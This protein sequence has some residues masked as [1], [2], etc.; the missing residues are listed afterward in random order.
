MYKIKLH[1]KSPCLLGYNAIQICLLGLFVIVSALQSVSSQGVIILEQQT[2]PTQ[3]VVVATEQVILKPGFHAVGTAG[4]FSA[5]I[6]SANSMSPIIPM[7]A[8]S[9]AVIPIAPLTPPTPSSDQNYIVTTVP[10]QAVS[11]PSTL[12]NANSNYSI[13]YFD[14]LGRLSQTVQ[15]AIT[16]TGA[17][18]VSGI[19]YDSFGR[20]HIHWLPGAVS[21]N[22][23]AY[24]SNFGSSSVTTNKDNYPYA[25]TEYDNSPLNRITGQYG[26]GAAWYN[27]VK[28]NSIQYKTNSTNDVICFTVNS[29]GLLVRNG[30]YD[31]N[32]LYVTLTTDEDAKLAAEYKDKLGRVVLKR[33]EEG[34]HVDTY[35]VFNDLGQ[36]SFVLPP[37]AVDGLRSISNAI[38]ATNDNDLGKL[39]YAYKYDTRGN[40]IYKKL[41]GCDPVYMVYDKAN[42][43][44]LSQDGNQRVNSNWTQLYYDVFGKTLY[45][46]EV[47]INVGPE[48]LVLA[49][50]NRLNVDSFNSASA[51]MLNTGYSLFADMSFLYRKPSVPG[52]PTYGATFIGIT[53]VRPLFVNYYDNYDFINLLTAD[54]DKSTLPFIA[55][56]G[57]D[58]HSN[59]A[60]GLL[61]GTR[62][63]HLED[64]TKFEVTANYYD[65]YGRM[66]QTRSSNHLGGYDITYNKLDFRGKVLKVRKEHNIS[67][68]AVA[69]EVYRYAYDK[70]ERLTMTRYK[71]GANDTI[72]LASNAYDDLGRI[73]TTLRHNNTDNC[74]YTY[75]IRNWKTKITSG[76]FEENLY[77]NSN[78]LP[79]GTSPCYNGNIAYST[80]TYNG[81]N[82]GYAYTYDGLNRLTDAAFKQGTSPQPDGYFDENFSYDSQGN[83]TTLKRKKDNVLIDD[84]AMNLQG[85]YIGNQL[86]FV[87]DNGISQHLYD[88]KE[89]NNNSS[90]SSNEFNYDYNGN[91]I[92]DSDRNIVAIR[93]N[94]LNL[95]D[96]IQF[97]N[98][99]QILNSYTADGRKIGTEYFTNVSGVNMPV[100]GQVIKAFPANC[101]SQKGTAY[102]DNK[103]YNTLNGNS[104]LT[105]LQRIYN[106]EGYTEN[107]TSSPNY[108]YYRRD[109]LGDNREVWLANTGSTVQR[110]Q[111][112][113]SGLPWASN[114]GDNPSQQQRKYNGKEFVEM[115]GYDT[116]DYGARGMYPAIGRFMCV[117]PH[118]E[119]Y[120]STSPYSYCGANPIKFV[121]SDGK[122]RIL[123]VDKK[124]EANAPIV[125]AANNYNDEERVVNIWAHGDQEG[126][127]V[128]YNNDGKKQDI[129][130][131]KDFEKFLSINSYVWR[132]KGKDEKITIVLHSCSTGKEEE[133]EK[134]SF[135]RQMSKDLKNTTIIAPNQDIGVSK[136][137]EETPRR[138]TVKNGEKKTEEGRWIKYQDGKVTG[139]YPSNS[140]PGSKDF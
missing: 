96:T 80:W 108:Y 17:D 74:A 88:I 34:G 63:Y 41:P 83:I 48:A 50:S 16:P 8:G 86:Q 1:K 133:E 23:G 59:S 27:G 106:A 84:L 38:E 43:L 46:M 9:T 135:A 11:D 25:T 53:V 35:Y 56:D 128:F 13:Q 55:L 18:L 62:M 58:G 89:Y 19:E 39:G 119:K 44:V 52:G 109:H 77:Y 6:G 129:T 103:E 134:N 130:N 61:T 122:E 60:K 121:D 51:T 54:A 114:G 10:Y 107:I 137:G 81:V 125:K 21:G 102:I 123:A 99:Y 66:V 78:D 105:S 91:M 104:A 136:D 139:S 100:T 70:A 111:Y 20:D 24:V 85:S 97:K 36:L 75:N 98:G 37:R 33:S 120:Y 90:A 3:V 126:I 138:E 116:Y 32:T 64:P 30:F 2:P 112:Y 65:K 67:G 127:K 14:G 113:P 132:T 93:Y 22:S 12:T 115:Q 140:K 40:C 57:Y 5:K 79:A 131:A 68:Q 26:A 45:S 101:F 110:T 29:D 72:T 7:A 4:S 28:K 69:P 76:S 118:A 49:F 15:Q 42:R 117:D 71:L 95:P 124:A 94:I 82:K 47:Q 87:N 31:P 92:K 73:T